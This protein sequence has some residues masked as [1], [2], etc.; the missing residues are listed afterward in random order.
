MTT[1]AIIYHEQQHF[2]FGSFV[3]EPVCRVLDPGLIS[4][5]GVTFA[6]HEDRSMHRML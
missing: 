6:R 4:Q 2:F 3:N 5:E 1:Y